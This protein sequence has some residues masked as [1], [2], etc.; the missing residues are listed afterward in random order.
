MLI[1]T[2]AWR[3][4]LTPGRDQPARITEARKQEGSF[5]EAQ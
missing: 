2:G 3:S 5:S 4:S 1:V